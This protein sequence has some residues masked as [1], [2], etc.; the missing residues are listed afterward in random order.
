M[1]LQFLPLDKLCVSRLNMRYSKRTPDVSDILPTIRARG[2]LQPILVRPCTQPPDG[3]VAA[4][5][6][7]AA[8]TDRKP[9]H[10]EIVA[11]C[12]RF[13][14]AQIVAAERLAACAG[15]GE[16]DPETAMLPCAVLDDA[17][18]ASAVEASL[19]E[20]IARLDPDEVSRWV[21]FARLVKEGRSI[22]DIGQT[23]GLPD[24]AVRR[25]LALGNLLPRIREMYRAEEIDA[26]TVRHLTLASK[27]HMW[28]ASSLQD[29]G[30]SLI[31]SH[32]FICPAYYCAR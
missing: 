31:G 25:I 20:N 32:A 3:P 16:P 27:S 28:T 9:Q 30:R 15:A 4:T 26:A 23:F 1:K 29:G 6:D 14:A 19:I 22:S 12:R 5:R 11:G 7:P 8:Q 24:L 18:D 2:I 10:Y 13:H 17:D 21:C